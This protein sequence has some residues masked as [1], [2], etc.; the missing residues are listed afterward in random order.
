MLLVPRGVFNNE[1]LYLMSVKD[2]SGQDFVINNINRA[3]NLLEPLGGRSESSAPWSM[4]HIHE[5][6]QEW[7][8]ILNFIIN[9]WQLYLI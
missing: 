4:L 2:L 7:T 1:A 3:F 6:I 5:E 9:C 8:R